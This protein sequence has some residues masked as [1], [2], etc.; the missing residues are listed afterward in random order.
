MFWLEV[1]VWVSVYSLSRQHKPSQKHVLPD[2]FVRFDN[3]LS[4]ICSRG[5]TNAKPYC[6]YDIIVSY[7]ESNVTHLFFFQGTLQRRFTKTGSG[8]LVASPHKRRYDRA[9]CKRKCQ[10]KRITCRLLQV[11]EAAVVFFYSLI[12][13]FFFFTFSEMFLDACFQNIFF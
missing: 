9:W 4:R 11:R 8:C 7:D 2:D 13:S 5:E 10:W 3:V 6:A 1:W 12:T